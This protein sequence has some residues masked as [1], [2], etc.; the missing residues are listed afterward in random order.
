MSPQQLSLLG[1]RWSF[2]IHF[3]FR[4]LVCAIKFFSQVWFSVRDGNEVLPRRHELLV[5][6]VA[7]PLCKMHVVAEGLTLYHIFQQMEKLFAVQRSFPGYRLL[8]NVFCHR[9]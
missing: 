5:S 6:C 8:L 2:L 7:Q 1:R 9:E 4:R 3:S